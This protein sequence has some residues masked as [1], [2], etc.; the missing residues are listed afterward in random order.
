[1][2]DLKIYGLAFVSLVIGGIQ[3]INP[4]IQFMILVLTVIS[5]IVKINKDLKK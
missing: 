2:A 3:S 5:L 4:W 1:M